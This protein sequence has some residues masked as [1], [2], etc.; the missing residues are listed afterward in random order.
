MVGMVA[1]AFSQV[2]FGDFVETIEPN[3][4]GEAGSLYYGW[5]TFTEPYNAPNMNEEGTPGGMLFNFAAGAFLTS[6]G[7][8]YNQAGGLDIHVY[9]YSDVQNAVL[10][11]ASQGSEFDYE[12][13]S[14]WVSDGID[15]M[16]F[17]A[18]SWSMNYYQPVEGMGAITNTSY[19]WN[20][21]SYEGTIT[22]WAFFFQGNEAHNV[23][24]AVTVD[25]YTGAV[26]SAGGLVAFGL[27]GLQR[28]RR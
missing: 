28:R 6:S 22:E 18:D 2:G 9:G 19:E 16:M 7:N 15:G 3:W 23:L 20:I 11:L 1:L 27:M 10:N 5:E 21:S 13:V 25:I 4:R 12:N 24:D 17:S 8:I 26:P 14:L